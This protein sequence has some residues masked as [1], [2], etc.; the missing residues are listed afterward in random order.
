MC[1]LI[2]KWFYLTEKHRV[3][4]SSALW[5]YP[6]LLHA[7]ISHRRVVCGRKLTS[8]PMV[9]YSTNYILF[10]QALH[11][12]HPVLPGFYVA[13]TCWVLYSGPSLQSFCFSQPWHPLECHWVWTSLRL[14]SW[15]QWVLELGQGHSKEHALS[16]MLKSGSMNLVRLV[17]GEHENSWIEAVSAKSNGW[18]KLQ[19][20]ESLACCRPTA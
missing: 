13:C 7:S 4:W 18:W 17:T 20:W 3:V 6:A 2:L 8:C 10:L 12:R 14:S 9:S 15:L 11:K 5:L 19:C 1:V 16:G